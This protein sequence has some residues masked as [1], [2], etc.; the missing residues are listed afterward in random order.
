VAGGAQEGAVEPDPEVQALVVDPVAASI[1]QLGQ[2]VLATT[3]VEL[4]GRRSRIRTVET[5]EG[6]LVSDALLWQAQQLAGTFGVPSPVIALQNGGGIRNDA[7][8]PIGPL[9]SLTTFSVLP[10]LNFVSV[11]ADVPR[12]QLKEI[13]EN[14]V[15]RVEFGDGRFSQVAGLQFVWS[16]TGTPQILDATGAVT[17]PGTRVRRVTIPGIGD[18][19][20]DG[21]VIPGPGISV[22]TIDFLARGGDQYPFRGLPFATLGVTYQQAFANYLQVGLGGSVTAA[23][24]PAAG[25][26]RI[27]QLP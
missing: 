17:T 3:D 12:E 2:T 23:A 16:A 24:Y 25:Q 26:G 27:V 18:I 8:I 14:A 6:N 11:V 1:A 5:N 13:L 10:F 19:V 20:T 22:A 4:D 15:S 7:I 9:S 21:A